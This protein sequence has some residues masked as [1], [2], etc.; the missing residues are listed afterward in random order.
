MEVEEGDVLVTAAVG[1]Q[2][3]TG[4][5]EVEALDEQLHSLEEVDQEVGIGRCKISQALMGAL[6]DQQNVKRISWLRVV[7]SD[8]GGG[9]MQA[10]NRNGKAHIRQ[11][12]REED[13]E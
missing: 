1:D 13:L 8:E 3:I 4:G 12:P 7:E 5:F 11:D 10:L 9:L 6:G 2:A